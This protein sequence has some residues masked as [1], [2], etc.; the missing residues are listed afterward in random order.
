MSPQEILSP[1]VPKN[2]WAYW[3]SSASPLQSLHPTD[4]DLL[5]YHLSSLLEKWIKRSAFRGGLTIFAMVAIYSN[6]KDHDRYCTYI[7]VQYRSWSSSLLFVCC[8]AWAV[9]KKVWNV[10]QSCSRDRSALPSEE[11]LLW[12][13]WLLH[14]I[15]VHV[16]S[17]IPIQNH[18][19]IRIQMCISCITRGKVLKSV[20]VSG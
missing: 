3:K 1:A 16:Y 17:Y 6:H 2:H 18:L 8:P 15:H 7:Y 14:T 10:A 5:L 11:D 12:L 19:H 20:G 9:D 4:H 13:L